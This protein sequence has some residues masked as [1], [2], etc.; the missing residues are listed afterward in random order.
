MASRRFFGLPMVDLG[1]GE[2]AYGQ[3]MKALYKRAVSGE[4]SQIEMSMLQS[5]V[6]WM[7]SPVMLSHSFGVPITRRGNVHQFFAPV[8]V[9]ATADGAFVYI[10]IGNERQWQGVTQLPG[11]ESLG[12]AE[13]ATNAGRIAHKQQLYAEITPI[14]ATKNSDELITQF[15]E[16]GAA[17]SRINQ[18]PDVE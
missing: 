17:I 10:S 16:I 15:R 6:S 8:S 3:V 18:M 2:H 7:V 9:F 1:A 4:G 5:A 14:F 13:Y 12:R 11:F